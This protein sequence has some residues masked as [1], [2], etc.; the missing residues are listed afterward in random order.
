[1]RIKWDI[2]GISMGY[3]GVG[4]SLNHFLGV[5]VRG[6]KRQG[7]QLEA[8][9]YWP[10]AL[11]NEITSGHEEVAGADFETAVFELHTLQFQV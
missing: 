1:L 4:P 8:R 2:K 3:H 11:W 9:D 10:L 7:T 6:E 5:Q